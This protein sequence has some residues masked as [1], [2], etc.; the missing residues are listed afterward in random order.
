MTFTQNTTQSRAITAFF[1]TK[2]AAEQA[3]SD[4]EAAG[5]P[6]PDVTMV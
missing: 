3:V 6:R 4:I 1:D 2:G 5:I